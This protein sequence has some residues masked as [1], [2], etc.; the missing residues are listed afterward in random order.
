MVRTSSEFLKSLHPGNVY[1]RGKK[2]DNVVS[3]DVLGIG[4][5]HAA[6]LFDYPDRLFTGNSGEKISKYFKV[7]ENT[8]DLISR[9]E[10]IYNTTNY[11]NGIFNIS[12]AIGSDAIFAMKIVSQKIDKK[13][14]TH[15][16]KNVESLYERCIKND[17]T[18]AVAQTDTKGDRSKRP[19]EQDDIDS[20]LHI[21]KKDKEGIYVTGAKVHTTQSI[22]ADELIVIP[23]RNMTKKDCDYAVAFSVSTNTPGLRF[24]VRPI[25]ELEGNSSSILSKMDF[26]V[27]TT[28]IFDNV[29]I[30]WDHVY[31]AGEGEFAG[32]LANL[33][34]TFHRFTAVSY[35]A[36]TANLYIGIASMMAEAN[37]IE[38]AG[39][40][41]NKMLD[42]IQ[43]KEIMTMSSYTAAMFCE[44]D[45]G[46]A[47]P[48]PVYTNI[49]K[50]YSNEN[51]Y[52]LINGLI[53]ISGGIIVTMPSVE[54]LEN[55]Q[56]QK[57][58]YK[59]LASMAPGEYRF[60]LLRLAKEL[61]GSNLAG[62]MLTLMAHAEGSVEASKIGLLRGYNVNEA[63]DMIRKIL[64]PGD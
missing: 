59:Y 53:E 41:K 10:L 20:Y 19:E 27:E 15:Y 38:N 6:K 47:V 37:G 17:L 64:M 2:I 34:A 35:R 32:E 61:A 60:N 24:I 4:A 55:R 8:E 21:T 54:D 26:E 52:R 9:R 42:M 45:S 12:Q 63:R 30:P 50:L 56:N 22:Y 11:C 39:H 33:F 44:I 36:A 18:L 23:Y 40:V 46:I 51:F 1:Y 49:G 14:N 62:Y 3:H 5:K 25:D 43:Y 29:F 7:P 13:Y 57:Y 16:Y 28:T 58:I 48:N 31:M